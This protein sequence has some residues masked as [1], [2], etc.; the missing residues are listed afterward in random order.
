MVNGSLVLTRDPRYPPR[1]V[2]PFD[3]WP[4]DP[5]SALSQSIF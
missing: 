3:P 5:L 2:D 4:T 1:F